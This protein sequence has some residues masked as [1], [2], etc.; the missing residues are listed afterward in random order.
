MYG[1]FGV[2]AF[3]Y[4]RDGQLEE[5]RFWA[6]RAARQPNANPAMDFIAAAANAIAGEQEA[7]R[8]WA[9]RARARSGNADS[10]HFFR[11]L[12]FRDGDLRRQ[13]ERAFDDLGL[14]PRR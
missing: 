10:A 8:A 11:A 5:A 6:N 12:P 3:S 7:A 9:R 1:F 14:S 2:H 13:L 4:L